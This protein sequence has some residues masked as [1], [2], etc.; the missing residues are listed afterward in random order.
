MTSITTRTSAE[1]NP[2]S[3]RW[4]PCMLVTGTV[5]PSAYGGP[6]SV[7]A[8]LAALVWIVLG[9]GAATS[10]TRAAGSRRLGSF[11]GRPRQV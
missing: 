3:D 8:A 4:V 10:G 9:G 11:V 7:L 6:L 2:T 5:P 1:I